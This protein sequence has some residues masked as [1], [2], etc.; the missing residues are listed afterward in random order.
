MKYFKIRNECPSDF[1]SKSHIIYFYNIFLDPNLTSVC[2]VSSHYRRSCK[3]AILRFRIVFTTLCPNWFVKG[4]VH[5]CKGRGA[6]RWSIAQ[7]GLEN[8]ASSLGTKFSA[9]DRVLE[10]VGSQSS[11]TSSS[12]HYY[13]LLHKS[14]EGSKIF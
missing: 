13:P 8:L 7:R 1:F 6:T 9:L 4:G 5:W 2:E 12:L 10:H 11:S 3:L 14:P